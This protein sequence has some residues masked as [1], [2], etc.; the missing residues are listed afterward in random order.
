LID[1]PV[2]KIFLGGLLTIAMLSGCRSRFVEVTID[3][4][5]STPVRLVEMDYPS[6]SFG[7]EQIAANSIYHYRFKIQGSGPVKLEFTDAQGKTHTAN[8][9][10]LNEGAEG[11]LAV[12]LDADEKVNWQFTPATSK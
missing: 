4:Q 6:A 5:A 3:N 9:P 1:R 11:H 8:G 12:V 2:C 7:T 10:E